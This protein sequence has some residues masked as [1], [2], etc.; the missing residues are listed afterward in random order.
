MLPLA[1][2]ASLSLT[3][4]RSMLLQQGDQRLA[5]TA[6]TYGMAVFERLLV[7]G[8]MGIAAALHPGVSQ[9]ARVART[10]EALS[11]VDRG[12]VTALI[13]Q[14]LSP[15]IPPAAKEMLDAGKPAV[16]IAGH[17]RAPRVLLIQEMPGRENA[18][19]VGEVK[20]EYLWG[21]ADEL[22]AMTDFCV[23]EE[24][25]WLWLYCS[26][27]M[28]TSTVEALSTP[29]ASTLGAQTWIR[30]GERFRARAWTQFMRATFGTR[31]WIV[32]ATQPE[33]HQLARAIQFSRQY[34]PV[35]GLALLLAIWFTI[36]QS[37]NIVAPVE[38]LAEQARAIE[39]QEFDNRLHLKREDELGELGGAFDRMAERLGRQF[40]SL[41]TLS[42]IDRLILAG[43][44]TSEVIRVVLERLRNATSA[45]SVTLTLFEEE[46]ANQ[47]RTYYSPPEAPGSFSMDR[48]DVAPEDRALLGHALAKRWF[49]LDAGDAALPAW[50]DKARAAGMTGAYV[51]PVLWRD[52]ARGALVFGYR[53]ATGVTEDDRQQARELAGRV[54]VAVSSAQRDEQLYMQAH[55][56]PLTG[57]A[58][59]LLIKDRID[60]EIA[61]G[62]RGGTGFAVLVIDLDH[63][64]TVNDS[65]GH[66]MGDSVLREAGRRISGCIRNTDSAARLGG[67]EFAVMLTGLANPQEG[68]LIAETI[69]AALSREFA[70]GDQHCFLSASAGIASF[71][72]DGATSE[73]L[74]KS[75]DTAMYRAKA[76]GRAQAVF[77]EARMNQETLA[78]VTLD[79]DVRLAVERGELVMHYQPQIDLATGAIRGAEALVRWHHATEGLISPL[80]FIPLAEESGFIE[81]L[82]QWTL[83]ETCTQIRR[84]RDEGIV[85]DHVAV[86]V[87]PRQFRRRLVD[88]VRSCVADSGIAP[89]ALEIEITE[90]LLLDAA[91]AVET[92]L[93]ELASMGH[94]IA[95]DDFGTGFSSMAYLKRYPV[96]TIKIDRVFVE[97][98][99]R[100]PDSEAIVAAIIAMSHALGKKV[101]AEGVETAEQLAILRK[102]RCDEVQGFLFSPAVPASRFAELVRAGLPVP[103]Q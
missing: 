70:L 30:D 99:G 79:R 19:V 12:R 15:E 31:D 78:R 14:K 47:A 67:D 11:I 91:E 22:P 36:R 38:Q 6:K 93:R 76:S 46:N 98:L 58:N 59:R 77:F 13:G 40:A 65:F 29:F 54:A 3:E 100:G 55:F 1:L 66:T 7:A 32:V 88:H 48:H 60:R 75:A 23:Y 9:D 89:S 73:E 61:R 4:V 92:M 41:T 96:S 86:N 84:W 42:E 57:L 68:W 87:S 8:D 43:S 102:L 83:R 94:A 74:L 81:Q 72:G 52:V 44:H 71:P 35:I 37:R 16:I 45:D 17:A 80:R 51:E 97:G 21:P 33:A 64:K 39:R 85:I 18:F 2:I 69:V 10:F 20:R 27:P 56:D 103:V 5:A 90:G 25:T 26:A 49:A 34:V 24:E 95:L 53:G 101:V 62:E 82:G 50:L 28:D 63:F